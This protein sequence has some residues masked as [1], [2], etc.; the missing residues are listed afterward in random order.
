MHRYCPNI[1]PQVFNKTFCQSHSRWR[2]THVS[3]LREDDYAWWLTRD[4]FSYLRENCGDSGGLYSLDKAIAEILCEI[5]R[6]RKELG[7][8]RPKQ[9]INSYLGAASKMIEDDLA[10]AVLRHMREQCKI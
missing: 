7:A 10:A 6:L 3:R 1:T 4:L 2:R 9:P 5:A 8:E